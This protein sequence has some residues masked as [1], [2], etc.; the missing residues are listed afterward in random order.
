MQSVENHTCFNCSTELPE[1]GFFCGECFTQVRCKN[2]D[3]KSLL[4]HGAKGCVQC[5]KPIEVRKNMENVA[6]DVFAK[7]NETARNT[8]IVKQTGN[9]KYLKASF[10]DEVGGVLAGIAGSFVGLGPNP[11]KNPFAARTQAPVRE[12]GTKTVKS[13]ISKT[14]NIEDAVVINPNDYN[15]ILA[16]LVKEENGKLVI[17]N[18]K[19][20][21]AGKIDK[22]IRMTLI[23][24]YAYEVIEKKPIER[25]L[26]MDEISKHKL[27]NNHFK[28]WLG[29]GK[30]LMVSNG[31]IELS[32]PGREKT[33]TILKEI[34]DSSIEVGVVRFELPKAKSSK[35]KRAKAAKEEDSSASINK[36]SGKMS[37]SDAVDE[38]IKEDFFSTKRQAG[39][40]IKYLKEQ[41]VLS[42]QASSLSTALARCVT[43]KKLK[44]EKNKSNNQYEYFI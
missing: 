38:L 5:G 41:K 29:S 32:F 9:R 3:C 44:R 7:H 37:P 34:A 30:E 24:L 36:I 25:S 16:T 15:A 18:S 4:L 13:S 10:S 2:Q 31:Q 21:D 20:K 11:P 22:G 23:L 26:I 1:E 42:F 12:I 8:I 43:T 6:P 17:V 28:S 40:I 19:L 27:E 14:D 33:E 39:E 35:S